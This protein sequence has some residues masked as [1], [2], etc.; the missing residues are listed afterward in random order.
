MKFDCDGFLRSSICEN[1]FC[2]RQNRLNDS[3][4]REGK[5][6]IKRNLRLENGMLGI[7][8]SRDMDGDDDGDDQT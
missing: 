7:L 5:Q 1:T 4:I 3:G 2:L 8:I 6:K